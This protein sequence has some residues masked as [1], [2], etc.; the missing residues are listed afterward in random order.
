MKGKPKKAPRQKDLTSRYLSGDVDEDRV[1]QSERFKPRNKNL[2]QDKILRT[3]LLR[4]EEQSGVDLETLPTGEVIQ[5]HSLFSDVVH[6][7]I[8]YLCV[9][10]KTLMK[11]SDTYVVVGDRVRFTD[12]T[13]RDEDGKAEASGADP[14]APPEGGIEQILPRATVLTRADS[15][16]AT[17]QH[18]IVANAQQML[19]V[20][21]LRLPRVKWGLV[22]RMIVAARSGGLHP[23][24]CLNKVDLA[25]P[26]PAGDGAAQ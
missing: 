8:T 9:I 20:A 16:K 15:F 3:A 2:Q 14:D 21:S 26:D 10:R 18:P 17:T 22:D 11:I 13:R 24:V 6:Q 5:V 7:G 19:I 25:E 23:I 12:M 4:A 1:E